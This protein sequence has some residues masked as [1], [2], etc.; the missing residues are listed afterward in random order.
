MTSF[1]RFRV[2][3]PGHFKELRTGEARLRR[4]SL[5]PP[6]SPRLRSG[7]GGPPLRNSLK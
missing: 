3:R 2:S 1:P 5:P 6:Y 4:T 7:L